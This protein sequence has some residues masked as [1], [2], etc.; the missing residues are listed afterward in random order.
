MFLATDLSRSATL[1]L[2]QLQSWPE[3]YVS[4]NILYL[5]GSTI[6]TYRHRQY[7][8]QTR[9]K[10]LG[11][12]TDSEQGLAKMKIKRGMSCHTANTFPLRSQVCKGAAKVSTLHGCCYCHVVDRTVGYAVYIYIYIYIYIY[13][14]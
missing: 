6:S 8:P 4:H 7:R 1:K 10:G 3:Y 2:G 5:K 11:M 12:T 13:E 14:R 9:A